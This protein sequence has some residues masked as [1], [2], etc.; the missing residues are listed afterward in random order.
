MAEVG[1]NTDPFQPEGS[2]SDRS[3]TSSK[4]QRD[5]QRRLAK[6]ELARINETRSSTIGEQEEQD[7][8]K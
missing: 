7:C 3:R 6:K 1:I 4:Q 5:K 8:L 2:L